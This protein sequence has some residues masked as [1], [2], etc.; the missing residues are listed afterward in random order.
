MKLHWVPGS[1]RVKQSVRHL[2]D[3]GGGFMLSEE[4]VDQNPT[5]PSM[6]DIVSFQ[7]PYLWKVIQVTGVVHLQKAKWSSRC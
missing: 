3:Q 1:T 2:S 7:T 4:N 6:S 5:H